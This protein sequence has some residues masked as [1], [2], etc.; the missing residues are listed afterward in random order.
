MI[1]E[2]EDEISDGNDEIRINAG[3][4]CCYPDTND[5]DN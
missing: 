5:G 1:N 2:Q 4:I 3:N